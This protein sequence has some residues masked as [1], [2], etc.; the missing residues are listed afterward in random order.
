MIP[1][2]DSSGR[3]ALPVEIQVT[4]ADEGNDLI[5]C[6]G[7]HGLPASLAERAGQW[8]VEVRSPREK[9]PELLVD[10]FEA[11]ESWLPDRGESV[12]LLQIGERRY[13]LRRSNGKEER[14]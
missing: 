1:T 4:S 3:I 9:P 12:P 10:L 5:V 13:A 14:E 2:R 7:R 6:L 8:H 11:V